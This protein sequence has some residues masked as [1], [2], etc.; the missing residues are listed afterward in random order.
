MILS[1]QWG[2]VVESEMGLCLGGD[3]KVDLFVLLFRSLMR[4][5]QLCLVSFCSNDT[6]LSLFLDS[7]SCY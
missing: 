2:G 5:G 3:L 1:Q 6:F 7:F 4:W